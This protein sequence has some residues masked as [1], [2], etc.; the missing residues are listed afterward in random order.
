MQQQMITCIVGLV[1]YTTPIRES[2]SSRPQIIHGENGNKS[3]SPN[4]NGH[5]CWFI[6]LPNTPRWELAPRLPHKLKIA[7]CNQI[8]VLLGF[9]LVNSMI[10][11][12]K[13]MFYLFIL[14]MSRSWHQKLAIAQ[15]NAS[16]LEQI[17][18]K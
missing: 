4:K 12:W 17:S 1:T 2:I 18:R 8:L 6:D 14:I 15:D 3:Q 9:Y 5:L 13:A 11:P 16:W 10:K 7:I